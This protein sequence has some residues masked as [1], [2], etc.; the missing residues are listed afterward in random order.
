MSQNSLKSVKK[1]QHFYEI[2]HV[3][4]LLKNHTVKLKN[5]IKSNNSRNFC[6]LDFPL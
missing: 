6:S 2:F 1:K 5:D 4:S 3:F